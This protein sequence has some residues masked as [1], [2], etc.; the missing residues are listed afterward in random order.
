[1]LNVY[2]SKGKT[3]G[4]IKLPLSVCL[5]FLW[6]VKSAFYLASVDSF[7]LFLRSYIISS[8]KNGQ[9]INPMSVKISVLKLLPK[10]RSTEQISGF[11]RVQYLH[12]NWNMNE[13][14]G[15]QNRVLHIFSFVLLDFHDNSPKRELLWYLTFH[16]KFYVWQNPSSWVISKEYLDN[17][18]FMI[19]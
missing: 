15:P 9:R 12:I 7:F 11:Q 2:Y 13:K 6:L 16:H 14:K 4:P 1:M 19:P 10:M 17:A 5:S 8:S 18:V 3:E